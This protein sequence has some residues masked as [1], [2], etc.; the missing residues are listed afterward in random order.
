MMYANIGS[1]SHGTLRSEDLVEAFWSELE[2]QLGRQDAPEDQPNLA[3]ARRT[4]GWM[5]D[6][7][8]N[9]AGKLTED[10]EVLS[11]A[12]QELFDALSIFAAPYTCFGSHEGDGADFGYWPD[13]NAIDELPT[14]KDENDFLEQ[15]GQDVFG[16]FKTVN[17][18]GN[19]TIHGVYRS[20]NILAE[21]V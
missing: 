18:H 13:R 19:V 21:F 8:W 14:Y 2:Y 1:I 17:D 11:E 7:L 15:T 16:D 10:Q 5:Q 12:V 3:A 9:E 20:T 6:E 4:L